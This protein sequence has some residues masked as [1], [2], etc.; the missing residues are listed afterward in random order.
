MGHQLRKIDLDGNLSMQEKACE[1]YEC[2][3]CGAKMVSANFVTGICIQI[4][5]SHHKDCAL[6]PGNSFQKTR[7]VSCETCRYWT[8]DC[9][10]DF[11]GCTDD[12]I[13]SVRTAG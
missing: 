10:C 4:F 5:S 9:G 13:N 1:H 7:E 8:Q 3:S 6:F 12:R 11:E 2:R